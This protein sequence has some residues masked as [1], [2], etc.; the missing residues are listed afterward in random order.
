M[1]LFIKQNQ[2]G[3]KLLSKFPYYIHHSDSNLLENIEWISK[4]KLE[5]LEKINCIISW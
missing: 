1:Q 4:F 3:V 5:I 2:R